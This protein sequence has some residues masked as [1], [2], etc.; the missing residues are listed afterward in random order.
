MFTRN[1]ATGFCSNHYSNCPRELRQPNT[2]PKIFRLHRDSIVG[3]P[4]HSEV[5]TRQRNNLSVVPMYEF[6][7]AEDES[8]PQFVSGYHNSTKIF[9]I[10]QNLFW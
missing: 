6:I 4:Y 8:A 2:K 5:L 7:C 1:A 3:R 10:F 9:F